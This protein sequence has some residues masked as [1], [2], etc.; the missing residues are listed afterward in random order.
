MLS[1]DVRNIVSNPYHANGFLDVKVTP[2]VEDNYGGN[3][4][5]LGITLLIEEGPQTVVGSFRW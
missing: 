1:A 5:G 2:K 4:R 3:K